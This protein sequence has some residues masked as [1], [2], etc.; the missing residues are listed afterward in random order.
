MLKYTIAR[1]VCWG[2]DEGDIY[3]YMMYENATRGND[4]FDHKT[5][6]IRHRGEDVVALAAGSGHL[7][8]GFRDLF[9]VM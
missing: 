9:G 2:Y 1:L 8:A 5:F 7:C 4:T 6:Q 3:Q